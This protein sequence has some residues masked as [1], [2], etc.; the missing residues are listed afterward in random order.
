ME[1]SDINLNSDGAS[2]FRSNSSL[3]STV[4]S[5]HFMQ[6]R[7]FISSSRLHTL[8]HLLLFLLLRLL[9]LLLLPLPPPFILFSIIVTLLP[10]NKLNKN[11][12]VRPTRSPP[13]DGYWSQSK[14]KS[15]H[16]QRNL[17]W[18]TVDERIEVC[19]CARMLRAGKRLA[20][21]RNRNRRAR[22]K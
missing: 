4:P 18:N 2:R 1:L 5:L 17:R 8:I 15:D 3:C 12:H 22:A 14:L 21:G 7:L 6:I 13:M 10:L 16:T 19:T 11:L 9:L 20:S